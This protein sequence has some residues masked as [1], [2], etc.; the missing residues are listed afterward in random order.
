[1]DLEGHQT[2]VL[3][4]GMEPEERDRVMDDFR[5]GVTK[6]LIATNVLARGI[7][8]LQVSLVINFDI[9]VDGEGRPDPETYLHRIG[10][11]GRF[12]RSGVSINFVHDGRSFDNLMFIKDFFGKSILEINMENIEALDEQLRDMNTN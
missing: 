8:I 6:V 2:S 7:D 3:H 4:G 5:K 9:P 12:G 11:T 10:R 1:M